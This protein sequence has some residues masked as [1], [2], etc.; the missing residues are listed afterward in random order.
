MID[1]F[2]V[3]ELGITRIYPLPCVL[4]ASN[5]FQVWGKHKDFNL[6]WPYRDVKCFFWTGSGAEQRLISVST[7][8]GE[9]KAVQKSEEDFKDQNGR[10]SRVN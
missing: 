9:N 8:K 10:Q 1:L 2:A 3:C 5:S 6:N 7:E 4:T